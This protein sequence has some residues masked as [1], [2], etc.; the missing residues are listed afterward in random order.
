MDEPRDSQG[1]SSPSER[2]DKHLSIYGHT[3]PALTNLWVNEPPGQPT[4]DLIPSQIQGFGELSAQRTG[5][6]AT[7][8]LLVFSGS[9]AGFPLVGSPVPSGG[10]SIMP[11]I[12]LLQEE[13]AGSLRHMNPT[14]L[15]PRLWPHPSC[16]SAGAET[17]QEG[18]S[19]SEQTV[20]RQRLGDT[21]RA[22]QPPE[23]SPSL[24]ESS[25]ISNS[26]NKKPT[27]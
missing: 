14:L 25:L 20:C 4:P 10:F 27:P 16:L 6:E 15:G 21:G 2:E 9:V 17:R 7:Y 22:V 12:V 3:H 23:R 24:K 5:V 19:A 26:R 8:I 11:S 18:P 1:K 13:E